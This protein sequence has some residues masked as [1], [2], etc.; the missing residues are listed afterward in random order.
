MELAGKT[1][2]V[3]LVGV[4]RAHREVVANLSGITVTVQVVLR[5]DGLGSI[6]DTLEVEINKLVLVAVEKQS[7]VGNGVAGGSS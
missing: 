3:V 7:S 2:T 5:N 6:A 1:H 4:G